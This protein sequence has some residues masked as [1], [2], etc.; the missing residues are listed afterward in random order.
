M[1]PREIEKGDVTMNE[2]R[3]S[4]VQ[5]NKMQCLRPADKFKPNDPTE[6]EALCTVCWLLS[7]SPSGYVNEPSQKKED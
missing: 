6:R 7:G 5:T 3:C 1:E 2:I 4:K